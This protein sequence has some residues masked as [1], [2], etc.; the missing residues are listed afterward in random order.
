[1]KSEGRGLPEGSDQAVLS[2]SCA[3]RETLTSYLLTLFKSSPLARPI[4]NLRTFAR[5]YGA[6]FQSNTLNPKP[7]P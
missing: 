2:F 1:M 5:Q 6:E 3:E 4:G 7:I